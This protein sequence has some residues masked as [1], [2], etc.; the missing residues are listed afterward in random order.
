MFCA[1]AVLPTF[2]AANERFEEI[3]TASWPVPVRATKC[4]APMLLSLMVKIPEIAPATTGVKVTV[5]VQVCPGV[6]VAPEQVPVCPKSPLAATELMVRLVKPL[7]VTVT[8]CPAL[9]VLST[10]ELKLRLAGEMVTAEV[11]PTPVNDAVCGLLPASSV[12]VRVAVR[13]PVVDGVK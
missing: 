7:L 12:M 11:A 13:V 4:G 9:V 10:C 1:G 2:V 6:N 8:F 5:E 3:E